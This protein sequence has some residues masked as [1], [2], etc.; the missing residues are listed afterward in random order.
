[1]IKK[2]LLL[3]ISSYLLYSSNLEVTTY[4]DSVFTPQEI[5][6]LQTKKEI[7]MCI[8][9]NWMPF[10]KIEDGKHIGMTAEYF[11]L[12]E[13]RI[14]I[15]IVMVPTKTWSQSIDF[16]KK[17]RCDIFSLAMETE[18]RKEY[19]SFTQPYLEAP[20]II[21][22]RINTLFISNPEDVI[23]EKLGI[24]KGYAFIEIFK[25]KYPDI[26]LIEF[27]TLDDGFNA[28]RRNEIFG[29]IDNLITSGFKIQKNYFGELKIAGKFED[30]W[31]L[32]IG[33][34]NDDPVLLHIFEKA[35]KLV[36]N[37]EYNKIINKWISIRYESGFDYSLF[38]KIFSL[39]TLVILFG[40]YHNFRLKKLITQL[41][42]K[43]QL[44]R[45]LTITDALSNLYNRRHFDTVFENEYNRTR[46][47][48]RPF[49]LAILDIDN[50]KKY[51]DTYGHQAGDS[52]IK[53]IST[54]LLRYTKRAGDFAFRIGGE[55]FAIILDSQTIDNTLEYF[56]KLLKSVEELDI[57]HQDNPPY[58]RVTLSIGVVEVIKHD[59]EIN[60]EKIYQMSDKELYF[61]KA[62]GKNRVVGTLY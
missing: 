13:K 24:T 33:V 61:A 25:Q 48:N 57:I 34:R 29:Y 53:A 17:R 45:K 58:N 40:I 62:N 41:Q 32:G 28:L 4:V 11:E 2:I 8:D 51:N 30:K 46:R 21:T 9:P 6:Y 37:E 56:E 1:M 38:W 36:K 7:K 42:E 50:F 60:V 54:V 43:D 59:E 52:V 10:E 16:A 49:I 23:G 15:P 55:E 22:T 5:E 14:G 26:E 20:L 39:F 31:A 35:I 12:F 18:S 19:M 3:I 44:L 27:E 47:S